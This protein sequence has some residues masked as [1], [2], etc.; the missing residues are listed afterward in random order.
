M[1]SAVEWE[2][3]RF[4]LTKFVYLNL[5]LVLSFASKLESLSDILISIK[6]CQW[7]RATYHLF[8][9]LFSV[10]LFSAKIH[11]FSYFQTKISFDRFLGKFAFFQTMVLPSCI[12]IWLKRYF[13]FGKFFPHAAEFN[14]I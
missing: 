5:K 2:N 1:Y 7:G 11:L 14:L 4:L 9:P 8:S 10:G 6:S 3:K 13:Q 12:G